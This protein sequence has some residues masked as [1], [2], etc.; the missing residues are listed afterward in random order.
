MS[1]LIL[2]FNLPEE[3]SES[4]YATEGHRYFCTLWDLDTKLRNTIK[5]EEMPEERRRALQEA[6]NWL[7]DI[8]EEHGL[9]LE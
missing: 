3:E 8:L 1:K 4:R 9:V 2:V 6:R 5:Y 7:Y